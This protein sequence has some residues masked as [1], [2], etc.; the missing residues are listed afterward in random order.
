MTEQFREALKYVVPYRRRLVV[1][2]SLSMLS[3]VFSL[4]LRI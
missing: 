2:M 1:V 4:V 3:T